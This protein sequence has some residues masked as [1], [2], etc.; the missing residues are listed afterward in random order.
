MEDDKGDKIVL[1]FSYMWIYVNKMRSNIL[2]FF[3]FLFRCHFIVS[4]I[5]F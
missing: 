5:D 4:W 3:G 1:Q 2:H